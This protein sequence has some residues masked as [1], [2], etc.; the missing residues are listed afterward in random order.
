MRPKKKKTLY[1]RIRGYATP[2][3][4][5]NRWALNVLVEFDTAITDPAKADRVA[6][7]L[8][9]AIA[10][11]IKRANKQRDEKQEKTK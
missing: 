7:K 8:C 1:T 6:G 11:V 3:H 5:S 9:K 10:G 2:V 4:G